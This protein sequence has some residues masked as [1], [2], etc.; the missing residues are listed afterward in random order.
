MSEAIEFIQKGGI[1][2][3]PLLICSILALTIV[4]EKI[5]NLRP[6]K[7]LIPE[8]LTVLKTVKVKSD[9]EIAIQL[10]KQYKGPLVNIILTCLE[11]LY[12]PKDDLKE[13]LNDQGRHEVRTLERGLV[14]LETVAGIAPLLGLLGT[15]TGMIK[16]FT[17]ISQQGVG[18]ANALAGGI[19]EALITTV[20]G[21]SI[22]I[23][24]LVCYNYFTSRAENLIMDIEKHTANFLYRMLLQNVTGTG[25]DNAVQS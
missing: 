7:V 3:V 6:K 17:V 11:N 24:S 25:S 14:L 2:M 16:V 21:L 10:C 12:L 18:Q 15:V 5:I 9:T 4:I 22:G 20:A 19:S 23:P 8:I 13:L 1:V